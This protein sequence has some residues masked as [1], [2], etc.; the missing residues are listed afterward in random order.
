MS[1]ITVTFD[2]NKLNTTYH[3]GELSTGKQL[4]QAGHQASLH[5]HL[6]P[7]IGA[8]GQVGHGPAGVGQNLPVV[9]VQEAHQGWKQLLH[10]RQR[11]C[12]VLVSTQVGQRPG[13]IAQVAG[14]VWRVKSQALF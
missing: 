5:H 2:L 9:V 12:R 3:N 14:L 4:D 11:R 1:Q 8:I 7:L 13:D 10:G 6:Y